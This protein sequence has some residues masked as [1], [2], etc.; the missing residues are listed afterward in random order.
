MFTIVQF[1]TDFE[2]SVYVGEA[3]HLLFFLPL[4]HILSNCKRKPLTDS[5]RVFKLLHVSHCDVIER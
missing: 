5:S 3:A 4:Y 1:V 2:S